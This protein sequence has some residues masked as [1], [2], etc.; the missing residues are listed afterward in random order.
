MSL[1]ANESSRPSVGGTDKCWDRFLDQGLQ[2]FGGPSS[3]RQ[4]QISRTEPPLRIAIITEGYL[5]ELS[6]VTTSLYQRLRWLGEW[7]HEIR[8]YAPDYGAAAHLYPAYRDHIGEVMP[9]VTVVPYPSRPYY[10]DFARDPKPFSFGSVAKDIAAFKPD[11][12]HAECAERLFMGF[13]CRAGVRLG[14]KLNIPATAFYHT[15]YLDFIGDYRDQIVWLR[16]PGV[17]TALRRMMVWVYN[18]YD[19]TMVSS[20]VAQRKVA[21]YG[22]RNARLGR[23]LGVDTDRFCPG[24]ASPDGQGATDDVTVVYVGRL[25]PDK[26]IG[27]LIDAFDR[28]RSVVPNARFVVAGGGP[29]EA[30]VKS[31]TAKTDRAEFVGRIPNEAAPEYYRKADIFATACSKESFGLTVLEAMACGA[32]VVGPRAGGVQEI[33]EDG[34]NGL[35]FAPGDPGAFAEALIALALNSD[36]RREMRAAA[37]EAAQKCTWAHG[38]EQMLSLWEELRSKNG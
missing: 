24:Q 20:N 2:S 33:V 22:V 7:G 28:L 13:L 4:T 38:A 15:N 19:A 5:P 31:W 10:V 27:L 37:L 30:L 14:R 6:G 32:P 9:G 11:V 17:V 36:R 21:D 12:V 23:F 3:R 1:P 29:E 25:S 16:V 8:L 35:L 34:K 18:S 26:E